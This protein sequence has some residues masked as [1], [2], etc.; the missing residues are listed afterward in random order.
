MNPLEVHTI[1]QNCSHSK[2]NLSSH[3]CGVGLQD[4]AFSRQ[5]MKFKLP[6]TQ[7]CL[8]TWLPRTWY[9]Y[10][11]C[12]TPLTCYWTDPYVYAST[13]HP[14]TFKVTRLAPIECWI[15]LK[16]PYHVI[17]LWAQEDLLLSQSQRDLPGCGLQ[18]NMSKVTFHPANQT[19]TSPTPTYTSQSQL[20]SSDHST[21]PKVP[22]LLNTYMCI[23]TVQIC[24]GS[25]RL[26]STLMLHFINM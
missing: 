9:H 26:H 22:K 15:S 10:P 1:Q 21:T 25:F 16:S 7:T 17:V 18:V 5:M 4:V 11:C 19:P 14:I 20:W 8:W 13:Q 12:C 2:C 6:L 3:V 23:W 24:F